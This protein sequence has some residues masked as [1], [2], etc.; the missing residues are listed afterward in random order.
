MYFARFV[1]SLLWGSACAFLTWLAFTFAFAVWYFLL[2]TPQPP[3]KHFENLP[4]DQCHAYVH[5]A[6]SIGS[7]SGAP[8]RPLTPVAS[9]FVT[10]QMALSVLLLSFIIPFFITWFLDWSH[11]DNGKGGSTPM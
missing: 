11:R 1:L 5:L 9:I 4:D 10:T 7:L 8:Y 3:Q 2:P 6:V